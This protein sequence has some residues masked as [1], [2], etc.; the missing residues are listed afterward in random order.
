MTL[1]STRNDICF[2]ER[3][4]KTNFSAPQYRFPGRGYPG[5]DAVVHG[6]YMIKSH[7]V[8]QKG[9]LLGVLLCKAN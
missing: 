8:T 7:T 4:G 2:W 5:C 1:L 6:A 9:G 3:L